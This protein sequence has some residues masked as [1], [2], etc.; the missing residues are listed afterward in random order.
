MTAWNISN[1]LKN[2]IVT[3]AQNIEENEMR[4]LYILR[5]MGPQRFTDLIEYSG[6]SRSTVSKYIKLNVKKNAI[7]KNIYEEKTSGVKEQRYFITQIGVEK[8]NEE[9]HSNSKFILFNEINNQISNLTE[10]I[11]FYKK[12]GVEES[13]IFEILQI[14]TKIGQNIFLFE[15]N[16]DFYLTLFYIFLNSVSTPEYKLEI[17][18]FC[19]LYEVKKIRI[20]FYIDKL[21]SNQIGF[22]M[23]T[24]IN[25]KNE[26]QTIQDIFFFH[27]ED[28]IGNTT[29]RIIKDMLLSEII[30]V[31]MVGFRNYYD[32]DKMAEEIADQ[33][34]K[35]GLI[36]PKIKEPFEMLI[37]KILIKN[38]VDMGF[39]KS[40]LM[41]IVIQSEKILKSKNGM[42][43][44]INIIEGSQQ[45]E[46]LNIVSI[47]DS[48]KSS[49]EDLL[50]SI[51]GFC[52]H[53]GK[54][55]LINEVS[56]RC[57]KCGNTFQEDNLLRSLDDA[58]A[59]SKNFLQ[60]KLQEDKIIECPNP[61]CSYSVKLSWERCPACNTP[62]RKEKKE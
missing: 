22:Y 14:I 49:R 3:T 61:N 10:L 48:L 55:I 37:E 5:N 36:W 7:E 35:M 9:P 8:L 57:S 30:Y 27:E 43:S 26:D 17:T 31:N 2:K 50:E 24:R 13:I 38:A 20:E 59:I 23:F 58:Y 15:Q 40:F 56:D 19:K 42:E 39:S 62:L 12:I 21:M 47:S 53:C 41:D 52:P 54:T 18:E 60:L 34:I 25:K 45:Y 1:K 32:L 11:T 16:R 51:K 28:I 46:D 44:L 29:L 6:L 4:I 33:I